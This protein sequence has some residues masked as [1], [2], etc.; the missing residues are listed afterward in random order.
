MSVV[1]KSAGLMG[2][3][4]SSG[5]RDVSDGQFLKS[6]DPEAHDGRG[7]VEWTRDPKEAKRFPSFTAAYEE[8]QFTSVTRPMREDGKPNRPLSA[9]SIEVV[10]L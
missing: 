5:Q 6:Y 8:W 4:T 10:T 9:Y 7:E 2:G 3:R 1:I